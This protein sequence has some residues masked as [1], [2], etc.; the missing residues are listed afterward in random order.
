MGQN[1]SEKRRDFFLSYT[2]RD[3]R[4]AEWI[5]MQPEEVGYTLFLQA[6]D[7]RPGSNFVVEMDEAAKNAERTLL[8]LSPSYLLSAYAFAEWAA[9][10]A[11]R[12]LQARGNPRGLQELLGYAGM[13][14]VRQ[15]LRW[16]DQWLHER[17]QQVS[18]EV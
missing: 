3:Q 10:L 18:E 12:Y 14:P 4:W 8:V 9:A 13:A 6:W 17:T 16:Y 11:M 1:D 5:A 7:F 15:Y 2:G